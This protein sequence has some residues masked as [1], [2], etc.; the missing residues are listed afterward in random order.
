MEIQSKIS[1]VKNLC[2]PHPSEKNI[3]HSFRKT[4]VISTNSWEVSVRV[5]RYVPTGT[6]REVPPYP[7]QYSPSQTWPINGHV[8]IN[9]WWWLRRASLCYRHSQPQTMVWV[10]C[11]PQVP[12]RVDSSFARRREWFV[13][14]LSK[15]QNMGATVAEA[16]GTQVYQIFIFCFILYFVPK[17]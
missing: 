16:G 15:C 1:P 11:S 8:M 3:A 17:G 12:Y 7:L 6:V 4:T 10:A 2:S 13:L 14:V 5:R 9:W